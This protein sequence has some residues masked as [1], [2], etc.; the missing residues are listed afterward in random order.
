MTDEL[1][2]RLIAHTQLPDT[3]T[4]DEM[5]AKSADLM[6]GSVKAHSDANDKLAKLT[7]ERDDAVK[8][9]SDAAG[10]ANTAKVAVEKAE[11][12]LKTAKA[13][14]ENQIRLAAS[15]GVRPP[16]DPVINGMIAGAVRTKAGVAVAAG[17]LHQDTA[18][19][20]IGLVTG[21]D[22]LLNPVALSLSTGSPDPFIARVFDTINAGPVGVPL[23]QHAALSLAAGIPP[24]N[25]PAAVAG[26]PDAATVAR[27]E[28]EEKADL[29][30]RLAQ[31]GIA[32]A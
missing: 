11:A 21:A 30:K 2:K 10:H 6:D 14:G 8:A 28:A 18:E 3:A 20:L 27:W 24:T 16:L 32:T 23:G 13:E 29:A 17:K 25:P 4:D 9:A 15:A 5:M 26:Q 22:G 19:K 12:E 7:K 1:R 31:R